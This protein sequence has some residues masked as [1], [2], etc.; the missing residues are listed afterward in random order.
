MFGFLVT[1]S[2]VGNS[3]HAVWAAER[4]YVAGTGS[5]FAFWALPSVAE[6]RRVPPRFPV[7]VALRPR[8]LVRPRG[9]CG[10]GAPSASIL[11]NALRRALSPRLPLSDA[12]PAM[13]RWPRQASLRTL[14]SREARP[15][16]LGAPPRCARSGGSQAERLS[17]LP[18]G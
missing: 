2:V 5:A 18:R 9:Q 11:C 14:R 15:A 4:I 13:R 3:L 7:L 1:R 16:P 12:P 10:R 6:R 17:A 8:C